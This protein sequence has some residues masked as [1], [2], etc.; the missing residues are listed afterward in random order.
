M[1]H[2]RP[3]D[4]P[5]EVFDVGLQHERTALAWERTAIATIVAGVVL[6]RYAATSG[7]V[8]LAAIGLAQ[9]AFGAVLLVW[10]GWHYD[11]LHGRLRRGDDVVH[12]GMARAVGGATVLFSGGALVLALGLTLA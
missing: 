12:P 11:E 7:P 10:S 6:A 2:D 8:A 3:T 9:T 5:A 4:R 1:S